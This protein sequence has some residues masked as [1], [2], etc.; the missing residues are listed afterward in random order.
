[1]CTQT[2]PAASP[3]NYTLSFNGC[4]L[5]TASGGS[6]KLD[7]M[8]TGQST[9]TGLLAICSL[10]P[11][12]LS[13]V[14]LSNVQVVAKNAAA[15][16]TLSAQFNLTGAV[17]A[18]PNLLSAC[19]V[20]GLNMTLT[21]TMDVQ[22]ATL[23]ETLM[24]QS[25]GIKLDVT[26]YSSSCVPVIYQMTLNGNASFDVASLGSTLSGTFTNFVF[27]DNTTSSND[28]VTMDGQLSSTCLGAAVMFSTPVALSLAPGMVC[29]VAGA[30]L[31]TENAQTDRLNYTASGG[32][33]IDLGNNS[34]IDEMLANCLDARLYQCP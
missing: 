1:M 21:G 6:V 30:V 34:S 8:I 4:V 9:E 7:G 26:Q 11:L 25:T 13:T 33:N 17:S 20:A 14:S 23:S 32:I 28:L 12:A 24:F 5:N 18:T 10:P 2:I 31:V 15:V 27:G 16:T 19:K 29:P 22:T 3:R